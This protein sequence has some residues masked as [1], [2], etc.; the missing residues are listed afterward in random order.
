MNALDYDILR[1][2]FEAY[3]E[4]VR[5]IICAFDNPS[6]HETLHK[7]VVEYQNIQQK[8]AMLEDLKADYIGNEK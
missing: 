1:K 4:K 8:L 2:A 3:A 6:D 5:K 7:L